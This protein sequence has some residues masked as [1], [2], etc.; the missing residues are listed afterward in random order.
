MTSLFGLPL[1]AVPIIAAAS[2][3]LGITKTSFPSAAILVVPLLALVVDSRTAAGLLLP[4][5]IVSDIAGV[6]FYR[7]E[8]KPGKAFRLLPWAAVGM[9]AAVLFGSAVDEHTFQRMLG[10]LII[11]TLGINVFL[12]PERMARI[13]HWTTPLIGILAGFTTMIGNAS[14]PIMTI[15]L[16]MMGLTTFGFVGTISV[17]SL[18]V[19]VSKIPIHLFVWRSVSPDAFLISAV[20]LPVVVAGNLIGRHVLRR[21]PPKIFR[22][23]MLSM[24]GLAGLRML[25]F[26]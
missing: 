7:K 13:P 3:L 23:V 20:M 4:I 17:F 21:V 10:I 6:W 16:F 8:G 11:V 9:A 1:N 26:A 12:E 19:N 24:A 5:Y 25:L 15:Y 2:L 14:G 18:I 22:A